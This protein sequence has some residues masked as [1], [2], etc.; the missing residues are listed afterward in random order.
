MKLINFPPSRT[1]DLLSWIGGEEDQ[2]FWSGNTFQEGLNP[3]VFLIHLQRKDLHS[4]A[5]I[6]DEGLLTC[7]GEIVHPVG[8][9]AV[10]CRVIVNP[11]IRRR[12]IGR[13]F[14][15][16]IINWCASQKKFKKITL[17]TF[18]HNQ[19]AR[20]CYRS[21]GFNEV[22]LKKKYRRVG[23]DWYDLVVMERNLKL[24]DNNFYD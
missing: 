10:L 2:Q 1:H 5:F 20:R 16:K 22:V 9:K 18:G 13:K 6:N 23:S 7:Y 8:N 12:G 15:Q 4:F 11:V 3:E 24:K 19:P 17:N 21:L 14:I